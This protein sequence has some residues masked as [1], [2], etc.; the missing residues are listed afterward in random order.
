MSGIMAKLRSEGLI[1]IAGKKVVQIR[2]V[3]EGTIYNPE[4]PA[5]KENAHLPRS[6]VLQ[7][8]L[9]DGTIVSARPSG[10][11]PKIKFYINCPVPVEKGDLA[12]ARREA[13][14]LLSRIETEIRGILD[15]AS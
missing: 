10:T 15:S 2:D 3:G 14:D 6:N 1:S 13:A 4:T 5:N 11:E 7:F 12:K 9:E 8:Y